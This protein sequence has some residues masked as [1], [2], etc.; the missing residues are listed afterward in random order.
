MSKPIVGHMSFRDFNEDGPGT[1]E[2]DI[3]MGQNTTGQFQDET[4]YV[5]EGDQLT[6]VTFT[7]V[8]GGSLA[9]SEYGAAYE[10]KNISEIQKPLFGDQ[11]LT[12]EQDG[13]TYKATVNKRFKAEKG[14]LVLDIE[15][16]H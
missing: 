9:P 13:V 2:W 5:L 14:C 11:W 16:W 3:V 8:G 10:V 12:F 6:E 7:H 15:E 1:V 4:H